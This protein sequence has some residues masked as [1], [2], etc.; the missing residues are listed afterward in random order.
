M[1]PRSD[2]EESGSEED[3]VGP[4]RAPQGELGVRERSMCVCSVC[5]EGSGLGREVVMITRF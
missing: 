3:E 2:S 4:P 1:A 5:V